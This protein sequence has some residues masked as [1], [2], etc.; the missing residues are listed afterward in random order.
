V[1]LTFGAFDAHRLDLD[2]LDQWHDY[3]FV[4][5]P[6]VANEGQHLPPNVKAVMRPP[7][8]FVSLI[9]ACDVVVTKPGYGIVSDCLANR[10]PVLFT[11]RGAFREYDVLAEALLTQGHACYIPRDDLLAGNVGP[12]LDA[13]LS[14]PATWAP[15]ATNGAR[16]VA[17]RLLQLANVNV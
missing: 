7:K 13:L 9:A 15:I 16:I 17:Q 3:V 8:N 6:P 5:T 12:H 4:I 14:T 11:D 10:V 2:A 1:L